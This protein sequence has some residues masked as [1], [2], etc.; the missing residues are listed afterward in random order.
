MRGGAGA[1]TYAD[2]LARRWNLP[3]NAAAIAGIGAAPAEHGPPDAG[4]GAILDVIAGVA[5][6]PARGEA[7]VALG[8]VRFAQVAG[9]SIVEVRPLR[10]PVLSNADLTYLVAWML[11]RLLRGAPADA[12]AELEQA[13]PAASA[14]CAAPEVGRDGGRGGAPG[15]GGDELEALR[16]RVNELEAALRSRGGC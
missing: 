3:R 15:A 9:R 10:R 8:E 12:R 5:F 14:P 2:W 4:V 6:P 1:Q 13:P 16:R 11:E 7:L